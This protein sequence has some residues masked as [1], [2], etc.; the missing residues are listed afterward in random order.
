MRDVLRFVGIAILIA[1]AGAVYYVVAPKYHYDY[2]RLIKINLITGET[3]IG[4]YQESVCCFWEKFPDHQLSQEE[5]K[6]L[7]NNG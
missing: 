4:R 3:F 7:S 5:L 2:K 6:N 1:F